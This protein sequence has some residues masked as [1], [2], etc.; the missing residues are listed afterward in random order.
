MQG[1]GTKP[2]LKQRL[3]HEFREYLINATYMAL[4]FSAVIFY[5]RALLAEHGIVVEDYFLGVIKALVIG[6]VIMVGAFLR[7]SRYYEDRPLIIPTLY[8][9]V[10]FTLWVVLF[11]IV[12]AW[13]RAWIATGGPITAFSNLGHHID[14]PW[15]GA[16]IVVGVCFLPFFA[17]KE[18]S[19]VMGSAVF[20]GMFF[21]GPTS[22]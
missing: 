20:R 7:L 2:T 21:K 14:M 16:V 11:D 6:K 19:R 15:L 8:K 9:T 5:R 3:L 1:A 12:E 10:L 17:M 22:R 4:F 13:I 18:A